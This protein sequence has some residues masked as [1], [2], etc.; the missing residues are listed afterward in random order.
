MRRRCQ[1]YYYSLTIYITTLFSK[2]ASSPII[3]TIP[4]D[5][6]STWMMVI[7]RRRFLAVTGNVAA[8]PFYP[9]MKV[10]LKESVTSSRWKL[11]DPRQLSSRQ[12]CPARSQS[13]GKRRKDTFRAKIRASENE[14]QT[15]SNCNNKFLKQQELQLFVQHKHR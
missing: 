10:A 8:L 4:T 6:N 15:R 3:N 7:L 11:S 12:P 9:M 2:F 14:E 13:E 5:L 1:A